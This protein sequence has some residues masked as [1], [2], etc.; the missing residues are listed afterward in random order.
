MRQYVYSGILAALLALSAAAASAGEPAYTPEQARLLAVRAAQV[1]A[2]NRLTDLILSARVSADKTVGQALGRGGDAEIALR[3][4]LRTARMA[5]EPRVYSDGV[6]ETDVEAPLETVVREVGRL[7]GGAEATA[8]VLADFR[9]VAVEGALR[10]TGRGRAPADV[11]PDAL[12]R[13]MAARPE[14]LAEL[15]PAGWEH[16]T[17]AGRVEA[18][19]TARAA[20]HRAMARRLREIHLGQTDTVGDLAATSPAAET[21]FDVF[22]RSLPVAGRPRFMPDR[23]AEVEVAASV[24]DLLR[25][26]KNVRAL[27]GPAGRWSEEEIDNLSVRL[28]ADA[29]TVTG[30]G[31]APAG[32]VRPDQ[33]PPVAGGLPLPDWAARVLEADGRSRFSDEIEDREEARVLAAR[34]AKARAVMALEKQL[35][36]ITLDDGRTIRQR[37]ARDEAFRRD[38]ATFLTGAR[39]ESSRATSDGKGWEVTVRLPLVRLYEFSRPGE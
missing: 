31:M 3:L 19:R 12:K 13:L 29:L 22:I 6:A 30:Y 25:V 35:D 15:Y 24:R 39:V 11:P 33:S 28:K 10:I 20:A 23:L 16:V 26:L 14:D 4:F 7:C 8:A 9:R 36:V 21:M 5:G 1:D 34:A 17:A 2:F 37:A 38:L 32:E 18:L 27:G